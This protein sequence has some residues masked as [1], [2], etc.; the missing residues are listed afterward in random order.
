VTS[1]IVLCVLVVGFLIA[2]RYWLERHEQLLREN[3]PQRH[4][5]EVALPSGSKDSPRAFA[6]FLRKVASSATSDAKT[7]R[8]GQRQVDIVYLATVPAP[9]AEP[10]IR[11]RIYGDPDRMDA[12]KRAVK[13]VYKGTCEVNPLKEDELIELAQAFRPAP[14]AEPE[15]ADAP[16]AASAQASEQMPEEAAA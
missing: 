4:G 13:Q 6:S 1:F 5:I 15:H 12:I 10:E 3:P 7:R 9:G 2:R 16:D 14:E 11:F 8:S